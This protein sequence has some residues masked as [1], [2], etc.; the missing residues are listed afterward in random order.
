MFCDLNQ[1][2]KGGEALDA[3]PSGE[4]QRLRVLNR[5][6]VLALMGLYSPQ[7][8]AFPCFGTVSAI[9]VTDIF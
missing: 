5:A 4:L 9:S 7:R 2:K 1:N 3:G 8:K 6:F